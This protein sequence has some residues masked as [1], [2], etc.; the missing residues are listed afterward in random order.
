MSDTSERG[1]LKSHR[2]DDSRSAQKLRDR[3]SYFAAFLDWQHVSFPL[4][5]MDLGAGNQRGCLLESFPVEIWI[6]RTSYDECRTHNASGVLRV[7]FEIR[8]KQLAVVAQDR[9]R[10]PE[11]SGHPVS[12]LPKLEPHQPVVPGPAE[13]QRV[14]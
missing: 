2:C 6:G 1:I 8:S 9:G 7:I 4:E 5:E 10:V 14:F 3:A 11:I 12:I 13:Q